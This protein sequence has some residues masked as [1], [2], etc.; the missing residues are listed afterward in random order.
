MHS[1]TKK[2]A[3]STIL[4]MRWCALWCTI[5]NIE[6]CGQ[7]GW[8]LQEL[9]FQTFQMI[10][11]RIMKSVP[12]QKYFT[13]HIR[14]ELGCSR[15]EIDLK[16]YLHPAIYFCQVWTISRVPAAELNRKLLQIESLVGFSLTTYQLTCKCGE[17]RNLVTIENHAF[18]R[19]LGGDLNWGKVDKNYILIQ[20]LLPVKNS[21]NKAN[22]IKGIQ[23]RL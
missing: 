23:N 12:L 7:N 20:I 8:T 11:L 15:I 10:L 22:F 6:S 9:C 13:F 19:L 14:S 1:E 17:N 5:A 16:D 4:G 2:H 18:R 21:L 3:Q